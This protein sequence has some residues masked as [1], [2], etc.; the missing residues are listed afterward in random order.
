[1]S[2]S[3]GKATSPKQEPE[4]QK[5]P[6]YSIM[7]DMRRRINANEP[8]TLVVIEL[9]RKNGQIMGDTRYICDLVGGQRF[10]N[11]S[12]AVLVPLGKYQKV[13]E[14]L[15]GLASA[16]FPSDLR[17]GIGSFPGNCDTEIHVVGN[18]LKDAQKYDIHLKY[19]GRQPEQAI[20]GENVLECA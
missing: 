18:V 17:V 20:S 14:K 16:P 1:M 6:P 10:S 4:P 5:A 15:E 12:V 7:T 19:T 8:F 13:Y 9:A 2:Y 3:L 11:K